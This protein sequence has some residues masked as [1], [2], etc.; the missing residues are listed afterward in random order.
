MKTF[1]RV[2]KVAHDPP[3]LRHDVRER[4]QAP[5][6]LTTLSHLSDNLSKNKLSQLSDHVRERDQAPVHLIKRS[7]FKNDYFAELWSGSE[8]GSYLKPID[9]C[10]T[11]L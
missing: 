4:D 5:G 10:I 6:N 11:P 3:Q 7:R 1:D 2:W 9:R 8:K